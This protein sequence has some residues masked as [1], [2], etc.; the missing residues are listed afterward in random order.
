MKAAFRVVPHGKCAALAL[1]ARFT[2]A[3]RRVWREPSEGLGLCRVKPYVVCG[4]CVCS[5]ARGRILAQRVSSENCLHTHH[6]H[7]THR[8]C[9]R[10]TRKNPT[11]NR[12]AI[13][14]GLTVA[15]LLLVVVSCR[16]LQTCSRIDLVKDKLRGC[17]LPEGFLGVVRP[18]EVELGVV[19]RLAVVDRDEGLSLEDAVGL[20]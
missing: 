13:N 20:E 14:L 3:N 11:R 1:S 6:A 4:A 5:G 10:P 15:N 12:P 7:R 2:L 17:D 19:P 16:S 9:Q 8:A 18:K